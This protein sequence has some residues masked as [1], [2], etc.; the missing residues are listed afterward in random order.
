MKIDFP[1]CPI[2]K[3]I[4]TSD[5]NTPNYCRLCGMAIEQKGE[6][7]CEE[8]KMEFKNFKIIKLR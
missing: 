6:F 7:C 3:Q 4:I 8:C 1:N 2:C 5:A